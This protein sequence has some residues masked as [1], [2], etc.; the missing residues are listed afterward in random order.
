MHIAIE[1]DALK[2]AINRRKHGV[3]FEEGATSLFDEL[4]L[5]QEDGDSRGE[6]RWVL[7]G[8]SASARLLTIVYTFRAEYRI[9]LISARK[10]TRMEAFNYAQTVRLL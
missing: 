5:A 6:A 10:A 1:W 2:A 8:M 3:S 9:R 4:A 7:V